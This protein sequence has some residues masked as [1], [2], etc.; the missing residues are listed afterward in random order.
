MKKIIKPREDEEAIFYTDF[1][2]KFCGEAGA[3][4]SIP[5]VD[6]RIEFNYT[7]KHDGAVISL[8]L[9]DEEIIP[10]LDTIKRHMS[11]D[12]KKSLKECIERTE[13]NFEESMQMRDWE[14]CDYESS[15]LSLLRY[16]LSEQAS[17]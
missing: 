3:D 4:F 6:L 9:D 14:S 1:K 17:Y 10:I 12:Y 5:P 7:S 11:E 13:R 2:G 15:S 16:M 8:H